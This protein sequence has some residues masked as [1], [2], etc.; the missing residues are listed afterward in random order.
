MAGSCHVGVPDQTEIS[1]NK[2]DFFVEKTPNRSSKKTPI[3]IAIVGLAVIGGGYLGAMHY[4]SN[5][6]M[7]FLH[8]QVDKINAGQNNHA[9][10][11]DEQRGLFTSTAKL[12]VSDQ[13]SS[14]SAP[15][16]VHHGLFST[17]IE[18]DDVRIQK[19]GKNALQSLSN[20]IDKATLAVH[21]KNSSL[22]EDDFR[23]SSVAL[24]L[25]GQ[26]ASEDE[27][28][29]RAK[30]Y[31]PALKLERNSDGTLVAHMTA[32]K[33]E[34]S[35]GMASFS[36]FGSSAISFTYD[37]EWSE[38]LVQAGSAYA[39]DHSDENR[40]ALEKIATA[41]LPDIHA[42][43]QDLKNRVSMSMPET[44]AEHFVFD[45]TRDKAASVTRVAGSIDGIGNSGVKGNIT[46]KMALDQRIIDTTMKLSNGDDANMQ[47]DLVALAQTSPR[48]VLEE[49]RMFD[50]KNIALSATG[51]A[52]IDGSVVKSIDD[53]NLTAVVAKFTVKGLPDGAGQMA[54]AYGVPGIKDGQPVVI[55]VDKGSVAVNGNTLF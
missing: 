17:D 48:V 5:K 8:A 44:G 52:S 50:H 29:S 31:N 47:Q 10:I 37:A 28:G 6:T 12:I 49:L 2:Q 43:M 13:A 42:D 19:D 3:I 15:L 7:D 25:P 34:T 20:D 21:L 41:H 35:E 27:D 39:H 51:E 16:T 24:T 33:V 18:S 55:T 53:F 26:L 38:Q 32:D 9:E 4:V 40:L 14:I 23:G 46:L 45:I 22:K 11:Q 1:F 30:I 54:Q 36:N